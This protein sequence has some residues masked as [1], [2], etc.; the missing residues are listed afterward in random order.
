M[1]QLKKEEINHMKYLT[2][3]QLNYSIQSKNAFK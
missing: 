2:F 3:T 1:D